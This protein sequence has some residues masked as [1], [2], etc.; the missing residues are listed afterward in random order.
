MHKA[1]I[2]FLLAV[3]ASV[4]SLTLPMYEKQSRFQRAGEASG[5][6]IGHEALSDVNGPLIRYIL[7]IPVLIAGAPILL[8]LRA[9]RIISAVCSRLGLSSEPQAWAFSIS[10]AR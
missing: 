5:V 7:A 4:L 6:E 1:I 2:S 9:V 3:L 10:R 8:R